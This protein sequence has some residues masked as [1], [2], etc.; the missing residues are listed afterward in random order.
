[1]ANAGLGSVRRQSS[2]TDKQSSN[3]RANRE[4]GREREKARIYTWLGRYRR[5]A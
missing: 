4:Y 5:V 1:L 2:L 3:R